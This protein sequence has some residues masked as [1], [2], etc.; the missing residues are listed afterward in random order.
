MYLKVQYSY[1]WQGVVYSDNGDILGYLDNRTVWS[2]IDLEDVE[3]HW[4]S[5]F[6][7]EQQV[8]DQYKAYCECLIKEEQRKKECEAKSKTYEYTGIKFV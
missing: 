1:Y 2:L 3:H 4:D 6:D 8:L 5:Q 7:T